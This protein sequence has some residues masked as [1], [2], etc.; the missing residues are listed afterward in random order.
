MKQKSKFD[1]SNFI[2]EIET[3]LL[4]SYEVN[5]EMDSGA[6]SKVYEVTEKAS[7]QVRACKYISKKDFQ[8]KDI[9]KF[10]EEIQILRTFDHPNIVKLYDYFTTPNSFYLIMEKC[11]GGNLF[12]KIMER[13]NLEK[14][15]DERILSKVFWQITSAIN[16]CHHKGLCHR[17]IKPENICFINL[18]NME[19]NPVK[20][21]DFGFGRFISPKKKLSSEVGTALYV[22]PEVLQHDYNEKCDIWSIGVILFFIIAGKPPFYGKNN[23]EIQK[24]ILSIDYKFDDDV[25]KNVSDDVKDLISHILVKEDERYTAE[26]VLQHPWIEKYKNNK[27]VKEINI[28]PIN[29]LKLYQ[30]MNEFEQKIITFISNRLPQNDVNNLRYFFYAL[31]VNNDGKI[32]FEEFSKGILELSSGDIKKKELK[33]IFDSID[34]NEDGKIEYTEFISSCINENIYLKKENLVQVFEAFDRTQKGKISMD[35]IITV[36]DLNKNCCDC[37]KTLFNK[38]DK[39]DDGKIDLEEFIKLF[40]II[41]SETL[42]RKK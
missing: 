21:I 10:E 19:N 25:W 12:Y 31:D 28:N 35:D 32:S 11:S 7:N 13:I 22:A 20:I 38:L 9:K 33:K 36:L 40:S 27:S 5:Y 42:N 39:D 34:T 16:Y 41:I 23:A 3:F 37:L 18:G 6:Y 14:L 26:Q 15:F 30:K 24:K 17:D 1:K 29:Q 8:E 4:D 2:F